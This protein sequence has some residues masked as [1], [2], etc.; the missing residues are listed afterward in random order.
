MKYF[1]II[2][3]LS[4]PAHASLSIGVGKQRNCNKKTLFLN[5]AYNFK[6]VPFL[7]VDSTLGTYHNGNIFSGSPSLLT[8]VGVGL[9]VKNK[10]FYVKLTQQVGYLLGQKM[11][12]KND[13]DEVLKKGRFQLP[14][15]I[16]AGIVGDKVKGGVFW[17]HY[18]NG[19]TS[20]N[21]AFPAEFLGV[22]MEV[23]L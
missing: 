12:V 16:S 18:S 22:E 2:L 6:K 8:E 3:M 1:L 19:S 17:K 20:P 13:Q 5:H 23:S 7:S 10:Y 14:T 9:E 11:S 4:L 15:K 21:N